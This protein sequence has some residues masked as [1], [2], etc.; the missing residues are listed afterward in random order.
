MIQKLKIIINIWKFHW[1]LT[2]INY[3]FACKN[4]MLNDLLINWFIEAQLLI[5]FADLNIL[6]YLCYC[7]ENY[8]N[9]L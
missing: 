8:L 2:F 9:R 1:Y 7:I 6:D 5:L 3:I 4:Y